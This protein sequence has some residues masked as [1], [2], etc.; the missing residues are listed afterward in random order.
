MS[1]AE[2]N[3]GNSTPL[4]SV[5]IPAHNCADLLRPCLQSVLGQLAHREDVELVVV[6]DGSTDSPD[7]V[8][9]E[10]AGD[11]VRLVRNE[12]ALGAVPNFNKCISEAHGEL[13]HILHGDDIV[14][15]G[16]YEAMEEAFA[17][18]VVGSA[19]C[20]TQHIN[21]AG[22]PTSVTRCYI[23]GGGVWETALDHLA[24]SNRIAAP[25]IVLRRSTYQAAGTFDETL[26]H[27]ADWDMWARAAKAAPMYFVDRVLAQYRVHAANDTSKR[28][29]TGANMSERY[30]A[31]EHILQYVE[32]EKRPELRRKAAAMGTVYAARQTIRQASL[33]NFSTAKVQGQ[34]AFRSLGRVVRPA[35]EEDHA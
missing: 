28:M 17:D 4:W 34:W 3:P 32:P 14:L 9:T 18:P 25:A 19:F 23:K 12:Q 31:L 16:F 27:A 8:V 6:D 5:V 21:G 24:A 10:L 13:I 29:T 33:R 22:D 2:D 1:I 26:P 35:G 15:P 11:R 7:A 20:R 30:D